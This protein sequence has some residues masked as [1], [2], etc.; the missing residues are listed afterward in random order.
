MQFNLFCECLLTNKCRLSRS[1][2]IILQ[3][4]LVSVRY[5]QKTHGVTRFSDEIQQLRGMN[6]RRLCQK[7]CKIFK[8][9]YHALSSKYHALISK[10]SCVKLQII[11]RQSFSDEIQQLRGMN[12]RRLC[13]KK[14]KIFKPNYH[15]L[16]SKYHAL[17]SK[18]SCIKLQI[19]TRQ[20]LKRFKD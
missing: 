5:N 2:L 20:R 11:T 4:I 18:L 13:Q 14:R 3:Q 1:Q 10:L 12:P 8:P 17:I 19:I 9:N 7:K 15:A 6:P 16:S